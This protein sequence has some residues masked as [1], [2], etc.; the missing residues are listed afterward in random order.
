MSGC[1]IQHRTLRELRIGIKTPR[2]SPRTYVPDRFMHT[3]TELE[4]GTVVVVEDAYHADRRVA[5]KR[6][7]GRARPVVDTA[8]AVAGGTRE[9]VGAGGEA[10]TVREQNERAQLARNMAHPD[11]S[12]AD[13]RPVSR[14][15]R[16]R[17]I[18]EELR[19]LSHVERPAYQP[20]AW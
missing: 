18:R 8:V 11:P 7:E 2:P 19:R 9:E 10:L 5:Q 14:A 12:A 6:L 1:A 17:L 13:Q 16:R 4:D 20:R 3:T 15:E